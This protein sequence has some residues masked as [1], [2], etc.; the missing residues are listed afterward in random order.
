MHVFQNIRGRDKQR[1]RQVVRHVQIVVGEGVILLVVQNFQQCRGWISPNMP[2]DLIDLVEHEDRVDGA[3]LFHR[4]DDSAG[5]RADIRPAVA[6]HFSLVVNPAERNTYKGTPERRR[7]GTAET[8]FAHARWTNKAEDR[9]T[10]AVSGELTNGQVL[11]DAIFHLGET[12]V[13]LVE[14]ARRSTQ[15]DIIVRSVVPGNGEQAV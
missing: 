5:K 7:D 8:G 12:I 13:M 14:P 15:V 4:L 6:A 10:G 9:W 3:C 2:A 1:A 11:H